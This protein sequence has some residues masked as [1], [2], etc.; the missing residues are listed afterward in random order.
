MSEADPGVPVTLGVDIGGTKLFGVALDPQGA[1][2]ADARVATPQA[3]RADDGAARAAP[4]S[5]TRW[6]RSS[7]GCRST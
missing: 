2:I 4:R 1:V 7:G 6:P 3:D 5:P